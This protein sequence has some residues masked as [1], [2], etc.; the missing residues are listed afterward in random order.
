MRSPL[1]HNDGFHHINGRSHLDFTN[2]SGQSDSSSTY[3]GSG[4][5]GLGHKTGRL[6][7][8][9]QDMTHIQSFKSRVKTGLTRIFTHE[10]IYI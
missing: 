3:M 5:M 6:K 7:W 2:G 8:V 9:A 10:S 4:Q 1:S